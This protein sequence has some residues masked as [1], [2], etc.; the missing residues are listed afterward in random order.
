MAS[1]AIYKQ[2]SIVS[3][4]PEARSRG[5]IVFL[6]LDLPQRYKM[7]ADA[8]AYTA[9][10]ISVASFLF[11]V[12]W[13]PFAKNRADRLRLGLDF[14][15]TYVKDYQ[16]H[17]DTLY[18]YQAQHGKDSYYIVWARDMAADASSAARAAA[19][20]VDDARRK[21]GSFWA[22]VEECYAMGAL[23][24]GR[25]LA[26]LL[27]HTP[28]W[29]VWDALSGNFLRK[30][31][32]FR[33]LTEPLD[34]ANWYRLGLHTKRNGKGAVNGSYHAGM[35]SRWY[36]RLIDAKVGHGDKWGAKLEAIAAEC[37][38]AMSAVGDKA[39]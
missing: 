28:I 18:D 7:V 32:D 31:V 15:R 35:P 25:P 2:N 9:F 21:L 4:D 30:A 36:Y 39:V 33:N 5:K 12:V 3:F 1:A 16:Q 13:T 19:K 27:Q 8:L 37:E 34:C 24:K 17:L 38:G 6:P 29:A 23:S 22:E 11:N 14:K 26:S 20:K 10:A